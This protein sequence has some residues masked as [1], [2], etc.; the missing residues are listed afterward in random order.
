M[1]EP[2]LDKML[3]WF[4][5]ELTNAVNEE[6]TTKKPIF[7]IVYVHYPL[8]CSYAYL[9]SITNL[10]DLDHCREYTEE[11][12]NKVIAMINEKRVD[13]VLHGHLHHYS[14]IQP[15]LEGDI[16]G[17]MYV[18]CGAGGVRYHNTTYERKREASTGEF[19]VPFSYYNYIIAPGLS[20]KYAND[21]NIV[22]PT[23]YC[24]I[25]VKEN[26]LTL[27]Y[28][29]RRYV[30]GEPQNLLLLDKFTIKK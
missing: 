13:L 23:G 19:E 4:E 1:D 18:I 20:G 27:T 28:M 12:R 24:D 5:S 16:P 10:D 17:P 7:K 30:E 9:K 11:V 15:L 8:F 22:G 3:Q 26:V 6:K 14:T 2:E 21:M 29:G 25:N